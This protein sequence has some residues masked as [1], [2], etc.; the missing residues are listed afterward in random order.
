MPQPTPYTRQA[1]FTDYQASFPSSPLSAVSV[2]AEFNAAKVTLDG[3]LA[4]LALVQR[5]DGALKNSVVTLDSLTPEVMLALGAG[6]IWLPRGAWAPITE[7]AVSDV[8]QNGTAS[9]VCAAE[10]TSAADFATDAAAGYWVQLFD[11]AGLIPADG[12]VTAAKLGPGAVTTPAIGFTALDLSG[13]IRGGGI[14]A[15]TAPLGALMHAKKATGDVLVKAER[16]TDD[17]GRVGFQI[18]GVG[19]TWDLGQAASSNA[20]ELRLGSAVAATFTAAKGIDV[21]GA[22]RAVTGV[23]PALGSGVALNYIAGVGY[24]NAYNYD[25][26]AWLPLKLRGSTVYV[27]AGGVDVASYTSTGVDFTG[28]VKRGG[29][30]LGWLDIPQNPQNGA[31]TL[32]LTDRGKHIYSANVS[33]QTVTIPANATVAFAT[34]S[35][36]VVVNDGSSNITISPASGVTLRLAGSTSTGSRTLAKNGMASLLKV[37]TDK[38]FISGAGIT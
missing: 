20:L 1:N 25:T 19:A 36:V 32:A 6:V 34:G 22:V 30:D 8:V 14:Q 23:V 7:Y 27:T 26:S 15:G 5:D 16:T 24:V 13:N 12:S 28:T 37:G 2:D 29:V 35:A 31:Y 4:A 17:Q 38:W 3:I 33:G 10:H 9:Y 21:G 18:I 11:S